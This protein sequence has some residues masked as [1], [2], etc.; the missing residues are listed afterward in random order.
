MDLTNALDRI[1][2]IHAQIAKG[3]VFRGYRPIPVALAGAIG[4]LAG[5]LQ[6]RV[7]PAGD[8]G[9]TFLWYWL[10]VAALNVVLIGGVLG[11]TH[12]REPDPFARRHTRQVVGQFLPCL[13]A[14]AAV[15]LTLPALDPGLVRLLPGIWALLLGLGVFASRPYLARATGWVALFFVFSGTALLAFPV[16]DLTRLGLANG[17]IFGVGLLAAA[18]VLHLDIPRGDR[19]E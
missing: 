9:T 8:D 4:L 2:E 5:W 15:S 11:V 16:N 10:S 6:P 13:A 12:M 7:L 17:A 14:G 3:E 19:G 1:E 18:M